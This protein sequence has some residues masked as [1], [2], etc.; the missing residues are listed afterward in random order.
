[1]KIFEMLESQTLL[2]SPHQDYRAYNEGF[3]IDHSK[4]ISSINR[5][6][7]INKTQNFFNNRIS[8]IFLHALTIT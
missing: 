4:T 5:G 3:V 7:D 2:W 8:L 1:M 6:S